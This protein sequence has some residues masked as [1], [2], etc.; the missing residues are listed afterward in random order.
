MSSRA[1]AAPGKPG[2]P[3]GLRRTAMAALLILALAGACTGA[4]SE[5]A[6]EPGQQEVAT[7]EVPER[8]SGD[9][10]VQTWLLLPVEQQPSELLA[11][12]QDRQVIEFQAAV[13]GQDDSPALQPHRRFLLREAAEGVTLT[14]DYQGDPPPLI[15]GQNYRFIA[16]ADLAPAA[17][18]AAPTASPPD[19][20]AA[21]PESLG[22]ELQIYD[23]AGLLFLGSTDVEEQEEALGLQLVNADGDCPAVPAPRND[24]V[25]SR[26]TL[27]LLVRWGDDELSLYPGEDGRIVH[28]AAS[29][30]VSLFRNRA[31]ALADPPCSAYNEHRRSLRIDRIDPLPVLPVLPTITGTITSTLPAITATVPFT[32]PPPPDVPLP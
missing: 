29:Y 8:C 5:P 1:D 7:V 12:Y 19:P 10:A 28:Q 4:N 27:P 24:C 30:V 3:G 18:T 14:L 6:A 17:A 16:W 23:S 31:V 20:R 22:Y 32:L 9:G 25:L 15:L 11:A 13:I 26:T 21:I 2:L